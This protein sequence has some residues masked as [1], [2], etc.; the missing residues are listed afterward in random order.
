MAANFG[1]WWF[2]GLSGWCFPRGPVSQEEPWLPSDLTASESGSLGCSLGLEDDGFSLSC[3]CGGGSQPEEDVP[4]K[5]S[6][7]YSWCLGPRALVPMARLSPGPLWL[8][9]VCSCSEEAGL[10]TV[11]L[12]RCHRV[13]APCSGLGLSFLGQ[14]VRAG[15]RRW[16]S[17]AGKRVP[18]RAGE[19]LAP[20][21]CSPPRPTHLSR[22]VFGGA[23]GSVGPQ[24]LSR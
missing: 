4:G 13:P 8:F 15:S 17:G 12:P 2:W 16:A 24:V 19:S 21:Y 18:T 3:R 20:A 14:W 6:Q 5:V 9:S 23:M 1:S 22:W 7:R 11:L 10:A